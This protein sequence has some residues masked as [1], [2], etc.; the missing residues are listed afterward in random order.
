M[1]GSLPPSSRLTCAT[2]SAQIAGDALAGPDRPGERDAVD[3]VRRGRA[4]RRRRRR[5]RAR[6]TTPGGRCSKQPASIRVERGVSS[7]GLQT[8]VFPA[9]SAGSDLPREQ[10]QRIVPGHD[11]GDHAE[12]LLEDEGELSRLDRGDH[13]PC[14]VAPHLGVVVEARPRS[15][16]PRR[17][18]RPA[19]CRPR[20]SSAGP[21]RRSGR[22]GGRRP[23]AAA[24]R[25]RS[26][27]CAPRRGRPP[28]RRPPPRPPARPRPCRSSRRALP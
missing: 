9:A 20:A 2:R 10:E 4:P 16:P 18:S 21:A 28:R 19:A 11:A 8:T 24:R 17:R 1:N 3:R 14:E 23:R 26:R 27:A 7:E 12:R 22:A 5:R 25:A 15:S 13:A 6:L